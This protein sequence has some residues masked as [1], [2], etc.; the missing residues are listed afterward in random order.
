MNWFSEVFTS[1]FIA[2][3][4]SGIAANMLFGF[5][6]WNLA[7]RARRQAKEFEAKTLG[8]MSEVNKM[9]LNAEIRDEMTARK[10]DQLVDFATVGTTDG[11]LTDAAGVEARQ[12]TAE[13]LEASIMRV[14]EEGMKVPMRELL[15]QL[16]EGTN[17]STV[18]P[19][20]YRLRRQGHVGWDTGGLAMN[21][22][23]WTVRPSR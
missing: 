14:L 18:V 4:V 7:R 3:V 22:V 20:L 21:S 15:N 9:T 5:A 23:L 8:L 2:G 1:Q 12:L 13:E 16:D 19:L 10:I 6:T 17:P 11:H